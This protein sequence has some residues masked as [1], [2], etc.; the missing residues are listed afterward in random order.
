VY[1]SCLKSLTEF[2]DP[3]IKYFSGTVTYCN[4]F[5][6]DSLEGR[7]F[8]DLGNV[9]NIAEVSVNGRNCGV[10]WT[11]PFRLDVTDHV[12]AGENV[13]EIKV[14]NLWVNRLIGD[15]RPE[16]SSPVTY[17]GF[18]HYRHGDPLLPSGLLGPVKV[19]SQSDIE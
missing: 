2:D 12:K 1:D 17:V 4:K 15:C 9:K 6:A 5:T 3:A 11:S 10:V 14:T 18:Q 13:I 19:F 8:L 7:I 16:E